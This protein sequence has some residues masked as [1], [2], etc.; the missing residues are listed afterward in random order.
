MTPEFLA[1]SITNTETAIRAY[2]AAIN[3][4]SNPEIM[5]YTI[6]T[7]QDRQTVTRQSVRSLQGT[8]DGLYNRLA[9]LEARRNGAVSIARPAY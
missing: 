1:T 4:F 5:S 7:G 3:A 6:D 8:I 2:E 9:T